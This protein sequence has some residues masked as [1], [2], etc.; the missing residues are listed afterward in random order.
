MS[1]YDVLIVGRLVADELGNAV[2]IKEE[3]VVM[4]V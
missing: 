1:I 3:V 4:G 2:F